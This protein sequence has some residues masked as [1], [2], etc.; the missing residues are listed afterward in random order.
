MYLLARQPNYPL[1]PLGPLS[2]F[3][4]SWAGP[5]RVGTH[6][7]G[8]EQQEKTSCA[9]AVASSGYLW[10]NNFCQGSRNRNYPHGQSHRTHT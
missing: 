10:R 8:R 2:H 7:Y 6:S 4:N 5:N 1:A 9:H 3:T